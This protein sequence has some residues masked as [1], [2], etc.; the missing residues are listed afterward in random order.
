MKRVTT[1]REPGQQGRKKK[2]LESGQVSLKDLVAR[3]GER[4][5]GGSPMTYT[6]YTC[7]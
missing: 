7:K 4:V 5:K 3:D 2:K 6:L 1:K